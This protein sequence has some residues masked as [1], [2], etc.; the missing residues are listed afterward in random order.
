MQT[1]R[2]NPASLKG[3]TP[4]RRPCSQQDPTMSQTQGHSTTPPASSRHSRPLIIT[5]ALSSLTCVALILALI[6]LLSPQADPGPPSAIEERIKPVAGWHLAGTPIA[7]NLASAPTL[8]A[9]TVPPAAAI[10]P[11]VGEKLYKHTCFAC[12]GTG[13]ADAPRPGDKAAWAPYIATGMD[14][15]LQAALHGKGI[16]PPKGGADDASEDDI[17]AAIE[18]MITR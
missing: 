7:G 5:I 6:A 2:Y 11:A 18:Y 4:S 9:T 1:G 15:M 8:S 14:A 10:D 12:H 16:M 13:V 17:R 3:P